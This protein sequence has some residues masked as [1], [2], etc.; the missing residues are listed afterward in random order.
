[1][2]FVALQQKRQWVRDKI[3]IM[4]LPQE[5]KIK[6]RI[7]T[8]GEPRVVSAEATVMLQYFYP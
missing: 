5:Y 1:M 8:G 7:N 4:H 3:F 2:K 6:H